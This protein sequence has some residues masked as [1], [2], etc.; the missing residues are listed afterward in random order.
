VGVAV[1][2]VVVALALL[3]RAHPAGVVAV[4]DVEQLAAEVQLAGQAQAGDAEVPGETFQAPAVAVVV[5]EH[6]RD[7]RPA[8]T[9]STRSDPTSPQ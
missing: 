5:A 7:G 3:G 6:E 1:E 9:S 4:L 8:S 2:E